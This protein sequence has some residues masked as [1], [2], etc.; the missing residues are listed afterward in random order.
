[1]PSDEDSGALEQ[2][3]IAA[4]Q[5]RSPL[6][7]LQTIVR[8]LL[9][10][11]TGEL[12][13]QQKKVLQSADR[14]CTE[15][16]ATV[17]G[18]LALSAAGHD[19]P[20]D[21]AADLVAAARDAHARFREPANAKSVTLSVDVRP[22]HA[23]VRAREP[24]LKEAVI[25][26]VDNA[27]KYTPEGGQVRLLLD[28]AP[29]GKR[30]L[31]VVEDSGIGIPEDARDGLFRPF[32]RAPNARKLVPAG[33]GLGLA[34]VRTVTNA[35][36]GAVSADRSP[37][38]GA[39]FTVSL[40][41]VAAP[42]GP[43][44]QVDAEPRFRVVVVG[45]VAAGSKLAAKVMRLRPDAHVTVVD[46]GRVLSYAGCGLPYYISGMVQDQ[47]ELISTPEGELRGL[48]FFERVKNVHVLN[49]TEAVRIDRKGKRVLI[50]DMI[51]GEQTWLRYD[52]LALAT[53][54]LPIVPSIPGAQLENVYTLH[55]LEHAEGIKAKLA[56]HR[57]RDV[58]IVGGGLIGVETTEA[59]VSAG[60][61]VTLVEMLPQLLPI[62]DWEM[63]ELV[64]RC[65]EQRGVKVLLNTRVTGFE[66]DG[67]VRRVLTE[68]ESFPAEMVIMGVGVR[69]NTALAAGAGLEMGATGAIKVDDHLRTS[70]PD[71][72]ACGDC[73]ETVDLITGRPCYVP[74]GSTA[75]KQGRAAAV[76]VCGGDE[77][78][79][80]VL[81]TTICKVFCVTVARAG[82]NE[83]QAREHGYKV[84]TTLTAGPDRAHYMPD[85][86]PIMIK[87]V[88]DADTR[89]LL[90][91]Q[92]VGP[93]EAAKR[94]DVAV[95]ALTAGMT[96]DQMANLDLGYAPP[97]SDALDN[98]HTAC[99]VMRNKLDG[100]M[101]G[102]TPMEVR[103]KLD[104]K[105]D[106]ILL[107]V[108][109]HT[110]FD[111]VS[112]EGSIH[113]PLEVL[114]GRMDEL[115][116]KEI[117]TFSHASLSAYEAAIKLKARGRRDV[118]VMD[119]GITMWPYE[120]IGR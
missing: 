105:D 31:L 71:V 50:R 44:Q 66:G 38:G 84:V 111:N 54:A 52:K 109:P 6:S 37:L 61:R 118:K 94:L 77:C 24:L 82:L 107:D 5:M 117:V 9:G 92:I 19:V 68:K 72:Y 108:R 67:V 10:G 35:A 23:F 116:D 79:P 21:A 78:F 27:V 63:S 89:R 101:I 120:T 80:G 49:R 95:A 115:P 99:N 113:I 91:I 36:G 17:G 12:T 2:A 76:N 88:A 41:L 34:L 97:Y 46:R 70:D 43:G 20:Y 114:A 62:L 25:A 86:A 30:A 90:G 15:A 55:G 57:A 73:V 42:E 64:R 14:K 47:R 98:L 33:T 3:V 85:A 16:L 28:V 110:Q 93:G 11:F 56:D 32:M 53:G 104:A 40:P 65:M 106:F 96:V 83:R 74:L 112:I 48:E 18:L 58:T 87:L 59:L 103:R 4:H 29:E 8:T 45:G 69:P 60:C 7:T 51:S 119:G 39:R 22:E 1:M 100:H 75:T 26:L 102:L 13:D 81:S